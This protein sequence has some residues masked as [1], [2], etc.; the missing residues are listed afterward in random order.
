MKHR[1][2]KCPVSYSTSLYEKLVALDVHPV[3]PPHDDG[4]DA[5]KVLQDRQ[6]LVAGLKN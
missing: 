4:N 1:Y 6:G 2:F 3:P 5:E